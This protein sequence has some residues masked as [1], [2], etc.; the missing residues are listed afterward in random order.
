MTPTQFKAKYRASIAPQFDK[1]KNPTPELLTAII[2]LERMVA[3]L[4]GCDCG[5]VPLTPYAPPPIIPDW[6]KHAREQPWKLPEVWCKLPSRLTS[7]G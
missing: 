5:P 7:L 4:C 2:A 6:F 1:V 3:E